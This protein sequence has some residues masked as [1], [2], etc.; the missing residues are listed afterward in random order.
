MGLGHSQKRYVVVMA[1]TMCID[2]ASVVMPFSSP[3]RDKSSEIVAQHM[4]EVILWLRNSPQTSTLVGARVIRV[5][6]DG[7]G[8]FTSDVIK[9]KLLALGVT[10]SFSPPHQPQ[11]NG[12]AERMVGLMKTTCR[13]LILSANMSMYMWPF[14]VTFASVMQRVK[15]LGHDWHLPV[16]GELVA[17]WRSHDKDGIK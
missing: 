17:I 14:A 4:V 8:E 1:V 7:G 2:G 10:Q 9:Q 12:L 3:L 13:R 15:L 11:S 16:F 6:S 5:M